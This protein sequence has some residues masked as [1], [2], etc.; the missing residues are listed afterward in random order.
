MTINKQIKDLKEKRAAVH[1]QISEMGKKDIKDWGTEER[2]KYDAAYAEFDNFTS[3][4]RRLEQQE[5]MNIKL[6]EESAKRKDVKP[7]TDTEKRY[8][9]V[10]RKYMT[11]GEKTLSA[12]ESEVLQRALSTGT[13]S[14]G[15]YLVPEL[16]ADQITKQMAFYGPMID[17][18]TI[19][20]DSSGAKMNF[21][22]NNDT[23]NAGEWVAE[24]AATT[25]GD[26]V[27]GEVEIDTHV[28]SSKYVAVQRQ[29]LQD[30][31]Y[32]LEAYLAEIFGERI[33]RGANLAFTTG[34]GTAKP[35][36][37]VTGAGNNVAAQAAAAISRT[38]IV[39]LK[40]GVNRAYRPRGVYQF[41][42]ATMKKIVLLSIGTADDRPLYLPSTVVGEPDMLEG[43][44][45]YVNSDIADV[46]AS[47]I[48][49]VYGD[50]K[51]YIIRT[52][53]QA[54][55]LMRLNELNALKYQIT[56]VL[57]DRYGG[58]L[59][60]TAAIAKLTHPSS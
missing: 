29:L 2:T 17:I 20:P 42:D 30:N 15:G 22:T 7:E 27:F 3:D 44:P 6:A 31:T 52:V 45:V 23:S 1:S 32:N 40:Y 34:N 47:A 35:Y 10:F 58:R 50:V 18:A 5:S 33:G 41:S 38:D 36:G 11:V 28:I 25:E 59:T 43:S 8:Q 14:E 54:R 53:P 46:A 4:I 48:S 55:M 19:M 60:D 49:G 51:K 24:K 13:A 26:P 37:I 21:P 56:F 12:D 39:N 16:W 9:E 57:F